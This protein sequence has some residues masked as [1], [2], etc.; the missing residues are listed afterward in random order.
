MRLLPCLA[1]PLLAIA[2]AACGGGG[3][4]AGGQAT[5]SSV[6]S[7]DPRAEGYAVGASQAAMD[8]SVKVTFVSAEPAPPAKGGNT[9]TVDVTD[10]MGQ[11][12]DG[13]AITVKPF[14]PDHGHGASVTP[15][16]TP[17][18]EAGRYEVTNVELF[19]P[20]IWEITFTVTATGGAP[21]PVKF[22]FCVDG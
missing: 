9:F 4:G 12:I 10:A 8:G 14:M 18:S 7:G 22:T 21:E 11:P 1:A 13:A 6:C 20:G 2:L 5:Q 17:G 19:M 16:V 15:T 3:G